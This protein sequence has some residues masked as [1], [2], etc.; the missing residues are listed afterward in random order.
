MARVSGVSGISVSGIV[1]VPHADR[2]RS[3]RAKRECIVRPPDA[4]HLSALDGR[5]SQHHDARVMS[6]ETNAP[7]SFAAAKEFLETHAVALHAA[8]PLKGEAE[9]RIFL[10]DEPG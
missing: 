2:S 6:A 4:R 8:R 1:R 5:L 10:T 3:A 9:V 7:T